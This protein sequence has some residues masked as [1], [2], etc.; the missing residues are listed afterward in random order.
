MLQ[1]ATKITILMKMIQYNLI[2]ILKDYAAFIVAR[3]S[4]ITFSARF[5]KMAPAFAGRWR[6][7][8]TNYKY[9]D[10]LK[11]TYW[12]F[13]KSDHQRL[14]SDRAFLRRSVQEYV[15]LDRTWRE[16]GNARILRLLKSSWLVTYRGQTRDEVQQRSGSAMNA[17][18][19][20]EDITVASRR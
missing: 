18:T 19:F 7:T 17:A 3:R 6:E 13:A 4:F 10:G 5:S 15:M 9:V 12:N 20:L 1:L 11:M 2:S 8:C 14:K 16:V